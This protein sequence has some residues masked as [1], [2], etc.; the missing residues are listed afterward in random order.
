MRFHVKHN[1]ADIA[2]SVHVAIPNHLISIQVRSAYQA[3]NVFARLDGP[4]RMRT[5]E[6]LVAKGAE[7]R[8]VVLVNDSDMIAIPASEFTNNA[9]CRTGWTTARRMIETTLAIAYKGGVWI[10]VAMDNLADTIENAMLI[11]LAFPA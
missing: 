7:L 10:A 2:R 3:I 9:L 6:T 5:G 8:S 1:L 4:G 11:D